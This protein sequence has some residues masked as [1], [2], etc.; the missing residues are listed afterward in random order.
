VGG[1]KTIKTDIRV[2]A[3]TN[4]DLDKEVNRGN[5][6]EDLFYRLNVIPLDLPPLRERGEDV[7]LLADYFLSKFCSEKNRPNLELGE[8]TAQILSGYTW[9]G[10][11]RE[12]ENFMERMSILCEGESIDP[13][14][15]PEKILNDTNTSIAEKKPPVQNNNFNWPGIR[16]MQKKSLGLKEFLDAIET[17]LL[18]EALDETEGVK[19]QAA[20]LLGIKRTTL[21]EKLKK[22]NLS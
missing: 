14:D 20:E 2:V 21:I 17:S 12:L 22:K 19:N 8:E 6:R 7:I 5:F 16:D 11:I 15:L 3:A 4:R 9:P 10:N 13:Q 1:S 18:K